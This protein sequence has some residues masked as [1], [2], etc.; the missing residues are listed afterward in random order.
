[1]CFTATLPSQ[2]VSRR[3]IEGESAGQAATLCAQSDSRC[4]GE[5]HRSTYHV[6]W[7]GAASLSAL[8]S[9]PDGVFN[10]I[11][12]AHDANHTIGSR[13]DLWGRARIRNRCAFRYAHVA[14]GQ[15]RAVLLLL[16]GNVRK[17]AVQSVA[18][19]LTLEYCGGHQEP[20]VSLTIFEIG[21]ICFPEHPQC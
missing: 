13:C 11:G 17:R 6:L 19:E 1:M 9:V 15:L 20:C 5:V 18:G 4:N 10:A 14:R 7:T 2:C 12:S 21:C 8:S 16:S 3:G